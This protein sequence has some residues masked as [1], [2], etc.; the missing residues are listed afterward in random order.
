MIK[1][2]SLVYFF[3]LLHCLIKSFAQQAVPV[4]DTLHIGGIRQVVSYTGSPGRPVLLFLHGGPGSSR[5]RQ[6]A[7]FSAELSKHFMVVQ[8]D[9]RDAGRTLALNKSPLPITLERMEEDTHELILAL[10]KKFNQSKLYLAGESWGT[11]P[12]FKMAASY[13][14]LLHA[15]L[16]FSPVIKQE[17]SER[18]LVD[19]LKASNRADKIALEELNTIKIPFENAE[20]VFYSRKWLF[21]HDGIKF[22]EEELKE[23]RKYLADWSAVWLSTWNAAMQRNLFEVLPGVKCPVYFFVGQKDLQTNHNIA[24][25]YYEQLKAPAKKLYAFADAGHSVLVEKAAEVQEIIIKEILERNE[26]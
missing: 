25:A 15:Y 5:M 10:L 26:H 20:Q 17:E 4:Y 8:W 19:T 16:A 3:L 22:K 9:Q 2:F 23:V 18:I 1:K 11:V 21:H 14:E 6:A 7:L 24:T 12:G 13:P